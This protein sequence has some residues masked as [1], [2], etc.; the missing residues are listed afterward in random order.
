MSVTH[1]FG[2]HLVADAE[3][4][5]PLEFIYINFRDKARRRRYRPVGHSI[6]PKK[7]T[8]VYIPSVCMRSICWRWPRPFCQCL[9]TPTCGRLKWP[10]LMLTRRQTRLAP[11]LLDRQVS[12]SVR[13]KRVGGFKECR[14]ALVFS[15]SNA[16]TKQLFSQ[17]KYCIQF[18]KVM[19]EI[20]RKQP[21]K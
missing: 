17:I 7:C 18:N 19:P 4:H 2:M 3:P 8:A 15:L 13:V 20:K 11:N 1:V 5:I 14:S 6:R 12:A 10:F 9:T 21:H 16:N